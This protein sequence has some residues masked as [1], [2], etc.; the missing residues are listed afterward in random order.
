MTPV[1]PNQRRETLEPFVK[2]NVLTGGNI[3]V[4]E[5]RRYGRLADVV[6]AMPA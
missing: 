2:S 6:I 5:L 4:D 1:V 3:H